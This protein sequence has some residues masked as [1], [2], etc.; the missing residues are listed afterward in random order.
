MNKIIITLIASLFFLSCESQYDE[1]L[2]ADDATEAF[3]AHD[4]GEI[5]LELYSD[6]EY[7][8]TI[9][10]FDYPEESLT[11]YFQISYNTMPLQRVYWESPDEFATIV[12]QDTVYTDVINFSTYADELGEG[13]QMV[14]VDPTLVG[15]TLNL[16]G[17]LKDINGDITT[18]KEILVKIQ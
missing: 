6:L 18:R 9:Y 5:F 14:Y 16:I 12:W 7:N 1:F 10:T 8:D 11:T 15:D 2:I 4:D 17:I 3:L 13:H